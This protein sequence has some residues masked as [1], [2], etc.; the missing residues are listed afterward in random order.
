MTT[1]TTNQPRDPRDVVLAALVVAILSPFTGMLHALTFRLLW[2]W[3]LAQQY[4]EGPTLRTWFG[5][6][7]ITSLLA[8]IRHAES[9]NSG[10]SLSAMIANS[11]FVSALLLGVVIATGAVA[12][13]IWGWA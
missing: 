3:F 2:S 7:A 12:R 1:A 11:V 9:K 5:I 6:S 4:G 13:M 10:E 8:G